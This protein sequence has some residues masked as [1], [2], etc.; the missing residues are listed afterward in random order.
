MNFQISPCNFETV[1]RF[2][3]CVVFENRPSG[4]ELAG[5]PRNPEPDYGRHMKD[6]MT[7]V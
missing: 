4:T 5:K 6:D 1:M 2:W 7:E 3:D